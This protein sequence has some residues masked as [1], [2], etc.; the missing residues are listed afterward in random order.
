M[1]GVGKRDARLCVRALSVAM[2][3]LKDSF[4]SAARAGLRRAGAFALVLFLGKS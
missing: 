4:M 3:G 2:S 1:L